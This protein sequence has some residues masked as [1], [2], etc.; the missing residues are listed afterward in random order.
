MIIDKIVIRRKP[1][2]ELLQDLNH[3]LSD[4]VDQ[5]ITMLGTPNGSRRWKW[6]EKGLQGVFH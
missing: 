5:W 3:D 1:L 2:Q 4:S 6:D